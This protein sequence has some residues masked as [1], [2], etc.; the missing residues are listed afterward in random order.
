MGKYNRY[1]NG[2]SGSM[3]LSVF[4]IFVALAVAGGYVGAKY[5]IAPIFLEQKIAEE[6]AEK[7]A[8]NPPDDPGVVNVVDGQT[9]AENGTVNPA[10][11][12]DNTNGQAGSNTGEVPGTDSITVPES[13]VT[14]SENPLNVIEDQQEIK[15][16]SEGTTEEKATSGASTVGKGPFSV[17]FGS[18]STKE[19]AEKLCAELSAKGIYAYAYETNGSHKVLGLPY[20]D[21]EKAKEAAS[22]VGTTVTDVFVV[23]ISALL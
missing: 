13:R 23:D 10:G 4:I 15:D 19:S 1:S 21:K 6:G 12:D 22:I 9:G 17:Q 16:V 5:G 20:A 2:K 8:V 18:F 11:T 7:L 3:G 14:P